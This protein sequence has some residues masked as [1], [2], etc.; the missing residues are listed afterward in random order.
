MAKVVGPLLS[1]DARG[2]VAD[3][4][5]FSYWRGQKYVRQW[6][7]PSNPNTAA[8]QT[9]RTRMKEAM[10]DWVKKAEATVKQGWRDYQAGQSISGPNEFVK[11]HIATDKAERVVDIPTNVVVTPGI[12]N[13]TFEWDT[14]DAY[15]GVIS[16]GDKHRVYSKT[17][18]EGSGVTS[19]SVVVSGLTT[20]VTY[21]FFVGS[22]GIEDEWSEAGEFAAVPT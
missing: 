3:A 17:Q 19:H 2:K 9:Q 11:R 8:Q 7:K 20:G 10:D 6:V 4:M 22:E 14:V 16:Y 18:T 12:N 21:Y 5:V 15:K 1:V 13:V